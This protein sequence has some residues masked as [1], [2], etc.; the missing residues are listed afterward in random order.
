M[1]VLS[2]S[3]HPAT[4]GAESLTVFSFSDQMT[5]LAAPASVNGN[6]RFVDMDSNGLVDAGDRI[7]I[8]PPGMVTSNGWD[9][10][11]IRIGNWSAGAPAYGPAVHVL[12]RGPAGILV[13]PTGAAK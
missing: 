4:S 8:H 10:Y 9:S 12:L 11:M 1:A 5:S 3:A 7:D 2:Q 6:L 13:A